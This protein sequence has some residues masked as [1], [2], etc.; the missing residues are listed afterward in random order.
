LKET[1]YASQNIQTKS[2][3]NIK[4]NTGMDS[5]VAPSGAEVV[6]EC[7]KKAEVAECQEK[8]EVMTHTN[9]QTDNLVDLE[10]E[11]MNKVPE[12]SSEVVVSTDKGL[13]Y[14]FIAFEV[15]A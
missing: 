4:R 6:T 1:E 2:C 15:N 7:Q 13:M 14:C 8:A 3:K 12:H 11:K 9:L 10:H 5:K